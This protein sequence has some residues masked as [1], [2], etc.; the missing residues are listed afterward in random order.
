MIYRLQYLVIS[1][2][3]YIGDNKIIALFYQEKMRDHPLMAINLSFLLALIYLASSYNIQTET[4]HS[5]SI[6]PD[7]THHDVVKK[8]NELKQ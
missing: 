6:I 3:A 8:R 4:A 5:Y 1:S 7:K 2:I